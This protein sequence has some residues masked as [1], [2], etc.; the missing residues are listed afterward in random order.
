[1]RLPI[2][3]LARSVDDVDLS[4]V[5]TAKRTGPAVWVGE[6]VMDI[7]FDRPLTDTEAD[8]VALLL[9]SQDD[10]EAHG[11]KKARDFL[12]DDAPNL[13]DITAQVQTLTDLVLRLLD[14]PTA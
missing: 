3:S 8:A 4:S 1:M 11:R 13:A 12:D 10:D 14:K 6:G 7:P 9:A 5:T 2:Q